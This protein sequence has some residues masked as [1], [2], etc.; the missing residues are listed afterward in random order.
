[1]NDGGWLFFPSAYRA[2]IFPSCHLLLVIFHVNIKQPLREFIFYGTWHLD[3][4]DTVPQCI[5]CLVPLM[6]MKSYS[7]KIS[8]L[9]SLGHTLHLLGLSSL[10][11]Y[12][13]PLMTSFS[14]IDSYII[15]KCSQLRTAK[16]EGPCSVQVKLCHSAYCWLNSVSWALPCSVYTMDHCLSLST[17]RET[18][19]NPGH[20]SSCPL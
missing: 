18:G 5:I 14:G 2:G 8:I 20:M 7:I 15:Y 9:Q 16:P 17:R 6:E 11:V 10:G 13:L 3:V 4:V 19:D 1:M 12:S